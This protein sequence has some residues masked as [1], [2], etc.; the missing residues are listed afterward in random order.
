ML[1]Y[2]S[3][4]Y[5]DSCSYSTLA[6]THAS[7]KWFHSLFPD[8][9]SNPLDSPVCK[10]L[11]DSARRSK[12]PIEKKRPVTSQMIKEIILKYA[13]PSAHLKGLRL[14]CLCSL[15]FAVFFRYDELSNIFAS[16]LEFFQDTL[17]FVA[18]AKND[19]YREGNYVYV[20][21]LS[22]PFCPI[23]LLRRYLRL[24][25]IDLIGNEPLFRDLR[26]YK[27]TNTYILCGSKLSYSR[28]RELFK[29]CL[30]K[31][32]YDENYMVFTAQDL[33]LLLQQSRTIQIFPTD[34][35]SCTVAGNLT[36]LRIC[37]S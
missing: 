34:C 19:I 21:R 2:L 24:G 11:L 6:L 4:V 33:A 5:S 8:L 31:L 10:N 29:E 23:A 17:K 22:S 20:N 12:G 13:A 1:A 16:H 32:G 37:I 26:Y 3:K 28:C 14:A 30:K 27:S 36:S 35:I 18:R 25:N 9:S 7:L 15:V